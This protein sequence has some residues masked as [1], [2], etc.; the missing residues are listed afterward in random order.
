MKALKYNVHISNMK[1]PYAIYN[2]VQNG[3]ITYMR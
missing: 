3:S 1:Y 2:Q